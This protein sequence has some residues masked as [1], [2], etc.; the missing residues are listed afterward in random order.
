[1]SRSAYLIF[2]PVA[3]QGN[4]DQDLAQIRALLEPEI[5]L[6]VGITSAEVD[7]TQLA[8]TAITNQVESILVSGGDGT[9]SATAAALINTTIPLGVI[10]RGTANAFANALGIPD[11]IADACETILQ[12]VPRAV[13]VAL[14]NDQPMVLLVGIGFE[15]ETIEKADRQA[16]DRFGMLAYIMAGLSQLQNLQSFEAQIET[17]D[18]I[19]TVP[20]SAITVANAAP[21]TS[22]LAQGPAEIIDN[23]GLLDLTIVSPRSVVGAIAASYELLQSSLNSNPAERDE[24]GYLRAQ[25]FS[26]TTNPPQKVV[27]DGE[28]IGTTP[29][30]VHCV[31]KGLNVYMPLTPE[32]S[33]PLEKIDTLPNVTIEFKAE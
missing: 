15:A 20:A 7:A 23:D 3:G 21:P 14:C 13:D 24:I 31:P 8:H 6:E 30:K 12:G 29:I 16:K 4:P 5:D 9:V 1:M 10:A 28:L 33:P 19:I 32:A 22:I 18:K 17:D 26:I 25:R 27:L 2:N 11:T